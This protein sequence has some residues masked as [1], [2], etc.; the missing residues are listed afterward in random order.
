MMGA[1][2]FMEEV[3]DL[4]VM[5]NKSMAYCDYVIDGTNSVPQPLHFQKT[6]WNSDF[7]ITKYD[8][9]LIKSKTGMRDEL[10]LQYDEN[11]VQVVQPPVRR[12]VWMGC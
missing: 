8:C 12:G 1:E 2:D 5:Q 9:L 10:K 3:K 7:E 4:D 6:K 11:H